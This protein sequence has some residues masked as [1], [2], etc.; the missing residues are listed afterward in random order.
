[1]KY[2][3]VLENFWVLL[4]ISKRLGRGSSF[5]LSHIHIPP[6]G[7]DKMLKYLDSCVQLMVQLQ[8]HVGSLPTDVRGRAAELVRVTGLLTNRSAPPLLQGGGTLGEPAL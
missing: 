1:M 6:P 7:G 3:V 4:Q 2:L 5:P 8:L